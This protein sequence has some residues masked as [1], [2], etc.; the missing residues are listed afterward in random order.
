MK[1]ECMIEP[2][3]FACLRMVSNR[4]TNLTSSQAVIIFPVK[5]YTSIAA[6]LFNDRLIIRLKNFLPGQAQPIAIISNIHNLL[7]RILLNGVR[8]QITKNFSAVS[9]WGSS[10]LLCG[11]QTEEPYLHGPIERIGLLVMEQNILVGRMIS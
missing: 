1:K 6:M 5:F 9:Y 10:S 2:Y 3:Q 8:I 4:W 11:Y 7:F